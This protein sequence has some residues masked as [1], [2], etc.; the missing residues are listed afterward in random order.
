MLI[1]NLSSARILV[2]D[3]QEANILF[4][5]G[6]LEEEDYTN[7]QTTSD[8]RQVVSMV[9][10]FQPDLI[11]LDLHMPYLDGFAVLEQLR[12]VIPSQSYLPILVLTADV[13]SQAK[14]RAL[15]GGARDFLT[16]PL[17]PL[18]VLLR[19]RNLLETRALHLY[20]QNLNEVLEKKVQERTEELKRQTARS[21]ALA[22]TAARLNA[23]LD[24]QTVLN[25]IC[26][27]T[28]GALQVS[29]ATVSL[30]DNQQHHFSLAAT[31]GLPTGYETKLQPLHRQ[32][33]EDY[34]VDPVQ[35]TVIADI[36]ALD[37]LPNRSTYMEMGLH[38][39]VN[40]TMMRSHE[41]IGR[42][43]IG[44]VGEV[45]DFSKDELLLLRGLADQAAQAI[46]NARFYQDLQRYST[47]LEERVE[48]RT[49]ALR[50]ANA[51][52]QQAHTEVVRALEQEQE[53]N[54]L[55]S[56]FLSI[57]SHEFRTPLA[58]ILSSAQLMERYYSRLSDDKK[59]SH[60]QRIQASVRHI[61][62]LVDDV[63]LVE[64]GR[65]G[66]LQFNPAPL[67][68][69]AFCRDMIEE[70][71]MGVAARHQLTFLT[72]GLVDPPRRLA[73]MDESLLQHILRNLLS[74]AVKYSPEGSHISLELGY[75]GEDVYLKIADQGIGIP[76]SDQARLFD[77]F[78]R[79]SNVG[80]ISG[81][82][83][84]MYIVK[85]AVEQHG[86][87]VKVESQEGIG[88]TFVVMLPW[89]AVE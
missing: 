68:L 56:R 88:T 14:Q 44:V 33:Y 12:S 53:L 34:F 43:N 28:A 32:I 64:Q 66:R 26:E 27:E 80:T 71:E 61:S 10:D 41:L 29:I 6:L 78:H 52:L 79:A 30:Y 36:Q 2:V 13:T 18:E 23:D 19:I 22:R 31:F 35:P 51:Q 75:T 81:T 62:E 4:L 7:I 48:E 57:A 20:Q 40:T 63:L 9:V 58:V 46:V 70:F 15:E 37:D 74:N 89:V 77:S 83:L 1:E 3:D 21:E 67:D 8:A 73:Q 42:L 86:G 50:A 84:G 11:L 47:Q 24:L 69:V 85:Q 49:I 16:K 5:Q 82:G 39:T 55:K 65:I 38:T 76:D 45:R 17:D 72:T 25:T 87:T 54:E 60:L 59:F